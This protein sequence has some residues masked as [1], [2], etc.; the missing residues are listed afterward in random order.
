VFC[1]SV[2]LDSYNG[3]LSVIARLEQLRALCL[4]V[5]CYWGS[6]VECSDFVTG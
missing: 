1:K 5:A 4:D 3:N 6:V 2:S